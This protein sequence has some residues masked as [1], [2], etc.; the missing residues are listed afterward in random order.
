MKFLNS[1]VFYYYITITDKELKIKHDNNSGFVTISTIVIWYV[2]RFCIII[3]KY[4]Y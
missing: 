2:V 3:E 1:T 4:N